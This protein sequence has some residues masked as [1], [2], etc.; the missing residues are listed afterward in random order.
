VAFLKYLEPKVAFLKYLE[1]R[2][3]VA[4]LK[5]LEPR[6]KVAFLKYLE[7]KNWF[8]LNYLELI[9]TKK[10][11]NLFL[12]YTIQTFIFQIPTVNPSQSRSFTPRSSRR[13][14]SAASGSP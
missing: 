11:Y 6:E 12:Y 10:Q 9:R 5:Y 8:F 4:F 2:E 13:A 3:K 14:C 7:P 1:P